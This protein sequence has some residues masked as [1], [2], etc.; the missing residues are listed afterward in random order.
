MNARHVIVFCFLFAIAAAPRCAPSDLAA[1]TGGSEPLLI[2][3]FGDSITFGIGF[4]DWSVCRGDNHWGNICMPPPAWGGGY[5]G[6]MTYFALRNQDIG[7]LT[8]GYQSAGSNLQQWET[9]TQA[10][11]GYPGFSNSQLTNIPGQFSFATATLV[12]AGTNDILQGAQKMAQDPSLLPD[13]IAHAA[14]QDFYALLQN[15]A[16]RNPTTHFYVAE[17][18]PIAPP[19]PHANQ[20]SQILDKYNRLL[21]SEC[22]YLPP[23]IRK[24]ITFVDMQHILD[25]AHDYDNPAGPPKWSGIH[26]NWSGYAK[27]ACTWIKAIK[28]ELQPGNP[29]SLCPGTSEQNPGPG[30]INAIC[31][32]IATDETLRSALPSREELQSGAPQED[33]MQRIFQ[34]AP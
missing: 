30:Q 6:W 26:P 15:L 24:R 25:P 5:R 7:F 34:P 19:Y 27:M 14:Q 1:E 13:P 23:E 3:P 11:D 17:I 32:G 9:N 8:E 29:D 21:K 18:I 20:A 16:A 2:R 28:G 4:V 33:L 10:H 12:H 22:I 31:S